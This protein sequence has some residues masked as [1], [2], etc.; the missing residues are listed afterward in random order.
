MRIA[1]IGAGGMGSLFGGQL[2]DAGVHEVWLVDPWTEH[3]NSVRQHGLE[4]VN[5]DGS[6][7]RI[8][9]NATTDSAEVA[10]YGPVDLAF[11][12]VKGY[13]TERATRQAA[14]LLADNGMMVT[15]QDGL[16]NREVLVDVAGEEHVI[17]GV[18]GHV[19]TILEAGR[20]R[21][22]AAGTT[23]LTDSQSVPRDRVDLVASA[24]NTAGITTHVEANIDRYIWGKLIVSAGIYPLTALLRVHNGVLAEE[25]AARHLLKLIV[26]EASAVA[27]ARGIT[28]PYDSTPIEHVLAVA[29]ETGANRSSML[30]DI[31]RGMPTEIDTINGAI[32]REGERLNVPTPIN[33]VLVALVKALENTPNERIETKKI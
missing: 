2:A 30:S 20:V 14:R 33:A 26:G 15:L 9:V 16:G 31:L 24:L 5:V 7:N 12:F 27:Y 4:L 28:L 11:I 32:A 22:A 13:A 3:V 29:R 25:N 18:T 1:M 10:E 6:T 21:H 23:Y 17:Q 8:R 19:G